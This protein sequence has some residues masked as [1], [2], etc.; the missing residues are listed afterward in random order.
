MKLQKVSELNSV[1]TSLCLLRSSRNVSMLCPGLMWLGS[2]LTRE[3][4]CAA[5]VK[6]NYGGEAAHDNPLFMKTNYI[7]A[8]CW[9][10]LYVLTAIWTW[11]ARQE[12]Y[13]AILIVV[14]NLVPVAMGLFTVWF[15]KWYPAHVAKGK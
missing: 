14:N 11:F 4:L 3:P 6:Y 5:Y 10:A 9:G 1:M 13:G 2:C 7:L 15:E 8:A 12:G